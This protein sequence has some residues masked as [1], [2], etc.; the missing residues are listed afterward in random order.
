M[1]YDSLHHKLLTLPDETLVYPAY[2]AGSLCG[3]N[4]RSDTCSLLGVQRRMHAAL[5]PMSK[6]AFVALVTVN[7]PEVPASFAFC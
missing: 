2:G 3:K 1:L 6:A 4:L 5:Q 7:Q